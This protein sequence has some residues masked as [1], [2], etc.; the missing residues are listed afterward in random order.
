MSLTLK[1]WQRIL[2]MDNQSYLRSA[3]TGRKITLSLI[4]GQK[5]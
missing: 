3:M 5:E 4:V 2:R 1:Y